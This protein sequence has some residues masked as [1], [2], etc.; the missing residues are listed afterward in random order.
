MVQLD[1][2]ILSNTAAAAHLAEVRDA[3]EN[4]GTGPAAEPP[5]P[6]GEVQPLYL[7]VAREC[8]VGE[9]DLDAVLVRAI[10]YNLRWE[11][12]RCAERA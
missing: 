10:P 9:V 4:G 6:E 2:F 1:H 8:V 11:P 3:G 5:G 7:A 12:L